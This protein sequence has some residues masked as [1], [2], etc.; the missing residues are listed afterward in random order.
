MWLAYIVH[1]LCL[2]APRQEESDG[3]MVTEERR[4]MEGG[5]SSLQQGQTDRQTDTHRDK[6]T[7]ID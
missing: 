1:H 4:V 5:P 7:D 3:G 2:R 6:Q